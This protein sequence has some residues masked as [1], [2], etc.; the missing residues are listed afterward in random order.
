MKKI[1]VWAV[2]ASYILLTLGFTYYSF[3]DF[4]P[5]T[6]DI[7][8]FSTIVLSF[9]T[10]VFLRKGAINRYDGTMLVTAM[11]LTVVT[12]I[13]LVLFGNVFRTGNQ[14][15]MF[16]TGMVLYGVTMSVYFMRYQ[17]KKPKNAAILP[18]FLII[19]AAL[20]FLSRNEGFFLHGDRQ[21]TLIIVVTYYIQ[22]LLAVIVSVIK[23]ARSGYYPKT[24]R[25]LLLL[26]LGLFI[27]GDIIVVLR[28]LDFFSIAFMSKLIWLFYT[29]SQALLAFSAYAYARDRKPPVK[30]A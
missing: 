30:S 9:F 8:K 24:N 10:A 22:V 6:A 21:R 28:N 20:Y 16:V 5:R 14:Y 25:V 2:I 13:F 23:R 26:G 4:V 19:P 29:P 3:I 27:I 15:Q 12:D 11:F 7:L 1:V 17:Y 18:F